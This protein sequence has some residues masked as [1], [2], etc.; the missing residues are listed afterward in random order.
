MHDVFGEEGKRKKKRGANAEGDVSPDKLNLTMT[1]IWNI[2]HP[3]HG[4]ITPEISE[5]T[6]IEQNDVFHH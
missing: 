4:D 1:M 6:R 3:A 2:I 5:K